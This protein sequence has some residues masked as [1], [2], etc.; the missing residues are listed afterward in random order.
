M[1]SKFIEQKKQAVKE[2]SENFQKHE[3]F[4]IFEFKT[5]NAENVT[6]LRKKLRTL[7]SKILIRQNNIIRRSLSNAKL[8]ENF[9]LKGQNAVLF[10]QNDIASIH[11]I[12]KL[13]KDNEFMKLKIAKFD[14]TLF[15]PEDISTLVSL[16][17]KDQLLSILA[18]MLLQPL[19]KLLFILKNIRHE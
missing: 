16:K 9:E 1:P 7:D 6:A 10:A 19:Y 11:E 2:L 12:S 15:N 13:S 3:T 14:N 5:L 18:G 4:L 17:G 8:F